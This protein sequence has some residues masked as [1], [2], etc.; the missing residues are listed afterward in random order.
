MP[1]S[2]TT[3]TSY[4]DW[5]AP[6]QDGDVLVWPD[7]DEL[8]AQTRANNAALSRAR[9]VL[10]QNTPLADLRSAMRKYLGHDDSIPLIATGHQ[11]ELY[12]AGVWAKDVLINQVATATGGQAFHF[13]VDTDGPKHLSVRWP[14]YSNP[15][16][17][18][19]NLSTRAWS[20]LVAPPTPRHLEQIERDSG[21][22]A[23]RFGYE[24]LLGEFLRS[25]RKLSLEP[26]EFPALLTN[27]QHALDW[28]LGLRHHA[29]TVS[30]LLH[31]DPYLALVHHIMSRA[32]EFAAIY[33]R[34]LADYRQ[35]A[36]ISAPTRPMPDLFVSDETVESPF[37][38]DDLAAGVRTRP[39]VFRCAG[40]TGWLLTLVNGEEFLFDPSAG[41]HAAADALRKFLARTNHRLSPRALTLTMFLRLLVADQFVHGIGGGRYD[42]VSDRIIAQH[43]G[44]EP[45]RFS[46]TTATLF[47]PGAVNRQRVCLP[48]L[49]QQGH[50]LEHDVLGQRKRELVES[51]AAL[52]RRS[53]QRQDAFAAMHRARREALAQ[54]SD[55]TR[56][57]ET[58]RDAEIRFKEEQVLF[59]REL[60]YAIQSRERLELLIARYRETFA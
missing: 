9:S 43:F 24:P 56:W 15:I 44:L 51:I 36:K 3:T 42:Q 47:F 7:R 5:K 58:M 29:M 45:P 39:S 38:L 13:A 8:I 31:A 25:L 46:V 22:I 60:F 54:S 23:G 41:A 30:G 19:P 52:P 18:D 17:D 10:V 59:D 12:H 53:A 28:S 33:N 4:P 14:G 1:F 26:D 16:S 27:A 11:S 2:T 40:C 34:A 49:Q 37:W 48:C 21:E 6:A 57:Q 32:D 35:A 55:F 50:R 20:A